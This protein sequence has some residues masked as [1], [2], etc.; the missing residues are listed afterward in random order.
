M[1]GHADKLRTKQPELIADLS[2]YPTEQGGRHRPV[3]LGW[4]CPCVVDRSLEE[5]EGWDGWPLLGDLEEVRPG[6][7]RRA[8]GFVFFSGE[9]AANKMRAAGRFYLWEGWFIGE[10]VVVETK[11][12]GG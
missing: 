6:E 9:E 10:A 8:V 2:L 4:G 11:P 7:T 5:V 12:S 3:R 1:P